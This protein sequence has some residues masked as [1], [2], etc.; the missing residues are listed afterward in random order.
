LWNARIIPNGID[1]GVYTSRPK[2]PMIMAAGRIWDGAKNLR[3]L[4]DIA[5]RLDWRIEIAGATAHPEKGVADLR[6]TR[7]L[8]VLSSDEM[9]RRLGE[10]AI[11]AAPAHYEPFGLAVLEAAAAGCA[12][13]LGGIPSLRENLEGGAI[14]LPPA[15]ARE[16]QAALP[17]LIGDRKERQRLAPLRVSAP[18]AS[19]SP[20]QAAVIAR[21]IVS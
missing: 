7:L 6:Q 10:A 3:L 4:D 16:W 8:G 5:P 18:S 21:S 2:R 19:R 1:A 14:F 20:A 12:L 9:R 17:R 11:F 15:E 13:V